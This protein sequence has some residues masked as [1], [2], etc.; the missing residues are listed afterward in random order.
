MDATT[1]PQQTVFA[2]ATMLTATAFPILSTVR[3]DSGPAEL[4]RLLIL[5]TM[6]LLT[7]RTSILTMTY[8]QMSTKLVSEASTVTTTESLMEPATR[9]MTVS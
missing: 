5:T 1:L 6:E 2:M 7:T 9:I 8:C 3:L 4:M